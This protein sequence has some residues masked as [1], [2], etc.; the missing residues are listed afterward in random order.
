[1]EACKLWMACT[2][3]II[4]GTKGESVFW[5][6]GIHLGFYALKNYTRIIL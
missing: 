5:Q 2:A 1:M 6:M 4:L 3:F